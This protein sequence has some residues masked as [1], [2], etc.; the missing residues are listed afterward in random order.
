MGRRLYRKSLS[1]FGSELHS[2]TEGRARHTLVK[3]ARV[4]RETVL[5]NR[6]F[7]LLTLLLLNPV[8]QT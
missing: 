5:D 3:H 6:L 2:I 8:D 7:V 1:P 4:A